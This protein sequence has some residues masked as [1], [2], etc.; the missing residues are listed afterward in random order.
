M[1]LNTE[2]T[3]ERNSLSHADTV[4]SVTHLIEQDMVC[5]SI[6]KIKNRKAAWASGVVSEIVKAGGKAEV[7]MTRLSKS[8][9]I[10]KSYS[11][12]MRT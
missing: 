11:S 12:R 10:R 6:S 1:H 5:E 9:Y 4:G 3:C 2:F 7:D 8:G